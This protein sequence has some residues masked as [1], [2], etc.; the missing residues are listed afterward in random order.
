MRVVCISDRDQWLEPSTWLA[1]QARPKSWPAAALATPVA[2]A[3]RVLVGACLYCTQ[4]MGRRVLPPSGSAHRLAYDRSRQ[5][6]A[7]Q[8]YAYGR[9]TQAV[10]HP[11][12]ALP[13]VESKPNRG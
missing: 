2:H 5:G 12:A 9:D 4:R 13:R 1:S 10:G 11:L 6:A 8:P 3:C 7:T